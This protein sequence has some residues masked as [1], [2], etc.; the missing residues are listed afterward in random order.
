MQK[1][2]IFKTYK[3]SIDSR[4]L[5][6]RY[7]LKLLESEGVDGTQSTKQIRIARYRDKVIC[8]TTIKI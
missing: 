5:G 2:A 7:T 4:Q 6:A 3:R 8:V 1:H